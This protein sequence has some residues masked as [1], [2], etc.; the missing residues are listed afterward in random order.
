MSLPDYLPAFTWEVNIGR[1]S[2]KLESLLR[3]RARTRETLEPYPSNMPL[4]VQANL[5]AVAQFD[6]ETALVEKQHQAAVQGFL[7]FDPDSRRIPVV[8]MNSKLQVWI[9][10]ARSIGRLM[11]PADLVESPHSFASAAPLMVRRA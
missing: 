2:T 4:L 1:L 8:A 9:K 5:D 7:W 10:E 6:A 11:H 3:E